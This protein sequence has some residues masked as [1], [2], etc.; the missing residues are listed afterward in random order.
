MKIFDFVDRVPAALNAARIELKIS[1]RQLAA[2]AGLPLRTVQKTLA[3]ESVPQLDTLL[4]ILRALGREPGESLTWLESAVHVPDSHFN[5]T[6][7][8]A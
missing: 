6:K 4:L 1:V 2:R 5:R 7:Q 3:G 8:V